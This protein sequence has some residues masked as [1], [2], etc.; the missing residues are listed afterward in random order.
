MKKT[1]KKLLLALSLAAV[2]SVGGTLAYFTD[3][4]ETSNMTTIGHVDGSLEERTNENNVEQTENGITYL[5]KIVPGDVISKEP[6][7][8]LDGESQS[9][10]ARVTI[11]VESDA[12]LDSEQ[13][14]KLELVK[15]NLDVN[16]AGGWYKGNDGYYYY[17]QILN[18]ND[19]SQNIFTKVTIPGAQWDNTMTNLDTK[20][21][22]KG[23]LIQSENFTPQKDNG[24]IVSWG[25]D[26]TIKEYKK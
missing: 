23:E 5:D 18:P 7:I 10:Y 11:S 14:A 15:D 16:N 20:I 25:N 8:V 19:E 9:A 3:T 1:T 4:D 21:K 22:I 26:I 12:N 17:N 6:Y 24:H 2:L 13:K